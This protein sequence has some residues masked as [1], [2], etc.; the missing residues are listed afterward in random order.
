LPNR[1]AREGLAGAVLLQKPYNERGIA[2]ALNAAM[3]PARVTKGGS[4]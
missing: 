4:T 3:A 1:D 2:D